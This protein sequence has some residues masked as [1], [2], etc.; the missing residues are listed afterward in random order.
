[1]PKPIIRRETLL[2]P[3]PLR[4][5]T[6]ASIRFHSIF[7]LDLVFE[8]ENWPK[9]DLV[10]DPFQLIGRVPKKC[11][12]SRLVKNLS[13]FTERGIKRLFEQQAVKIR[14]SLPR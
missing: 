14:P 13:A 8:H 1:M 5:L 2:L 4:F 9:R 6:H 12:K 3:A 11:S 7:K 10:A